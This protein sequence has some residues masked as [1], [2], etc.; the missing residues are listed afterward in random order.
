MRAIGTILTLVLAQAAWAGAAWDGNHCVIC[1]EAERLP[2]SLG[3]TFE[4]WRGSA[5]AR[6]GVGCERCH[7]GDPRARDAAA[8]HTGA[9][10]AGDAGSMIH[11]TRLPATCGGCHPKELAAFSGTAHMRE[12]D[13]KG[14]GATCLTC[15]GA[16]A[17]SLPAPAYLGERCA[18]CHRTPVQAEAALGVL[19]TVKLQLRRTRMAVDAVEATDAGWHASA[20]AR[21]HDL[22]RSYR[23]IQLKWHTFK[24]REILRESGDLLQLA[25]LLGEEAVVKGRRHTP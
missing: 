9:L 5:H 19:A 13:A 20:V 17:T 6:G 25:K 12:L 14:K 21:F 22:E 2:I 11:P 23:D 7:G 3:H 24:T 8:A 16:M 18:V 15:H 4:D 10:P 1:H